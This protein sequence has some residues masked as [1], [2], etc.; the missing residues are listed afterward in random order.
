VALVPPQPKFADVEYPEFLR[1]VAWPMTDLCLLALLLV[2]ECNERGRIVASG[3]GGGWS[4]QPHQGDGHHEDADGEQA[5]PS[6]RVPCIV[7]PRQLR[8]NTHDVP[9]E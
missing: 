8:E 5:A 9:Q 7:D 6:L 3:K 4:T 1:V 2:L